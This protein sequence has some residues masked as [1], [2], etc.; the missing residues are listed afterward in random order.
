MAAA[1]VVA[2]G[3]IRSQRQD[4]MLSLDLLLLPENIILSAPPAQLVVRLLAVA[5]PEILR[6]YFEMLQLSVL[7]HTAAL[8][9]ASC[10]SL[11]TKLALVYAFHRKPITLQ[12]S[13]A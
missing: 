5:R 2:N 10:V 6:L 4:L 3:H 11:K 12:I 7:A 13:A 1:H 9:G 8:L